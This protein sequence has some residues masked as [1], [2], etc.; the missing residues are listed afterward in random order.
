MALSSTPSLTEINTELGVT[1]K[2][3]S[4]CIALAG[5]TG[6]WTKQSDFAGYSADSI[7]INPASVDIDHTIQTVGTTVTSSSDWEINT[8]TVP[9]WVAIITGSGSSGNLCDMAV[10]YNDTGAPRTANIEIRL[11]SNNTIKTIFTISQ[12]ATI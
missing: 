9:S 3:L 10:D 1:G 11:I 6:T 12:T 4:E 2:S 8:L 7:S 5:K